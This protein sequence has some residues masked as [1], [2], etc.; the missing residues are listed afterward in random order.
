L[1]AEGNE[2]LPAIFADLYNTEL[3]YG[4]D[5]SMPQQHKIEQTNRTAGDNV[6]NLSHFRE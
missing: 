3:F 4:V 6:L 2:A 5:G 1:T